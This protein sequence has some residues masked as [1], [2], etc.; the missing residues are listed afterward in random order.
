VA[1]VARNLKDL[2]KKP[3]RATRAAV[4]SPSDR[5]KSVPPFGE[6]ADCKGRHADMKSVW[7]LCV[8]SLV[9]LIGLG[10]TR[11][12]GGHGHGTT[13]HASH[14]PKS[15]K[16]GSKKSGGKPSAHPAGGHQPPKSHPKPKDSKSE[17]HE[18]AKA[19]NAQGKPGNPKG[20]AD[21][22]KHVAKDGKGASQKDQLA[23]P[24]AMT[25]GSV[26][27]QTSLTHSTHEFHHD[28]WV[29]GHHHIWSADGYWVDAA[30]GLPVATD[31]GAPADGSAA[32][33]PAAA[34]TAVSGRPQIHFSVDPAER[35]SY[36]VAAQNA[37]MSRGE[38]IRSRLDA[39]IQQE[40]R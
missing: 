38:W 8:A 12:F 18:S 34:A 20:N 39:A 23:H 37:G 36:D 4:L 5:C 19:G 21:A 22:S 14:T 25:T 35:D 27:A 7:L 16:E 2:S 26:S 32:T 6:I 15:H 3:H 24:N 40:L 13:S 33:V 30:T 28:R 29:H 31:P 9:G 11:T 10:E 17:M 1:S